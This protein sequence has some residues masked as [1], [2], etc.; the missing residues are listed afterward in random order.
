MKRLLKRLRRWSLQKYFSKPKETGET[1]ST[2]VTAPDVWDEPFAAT[3][4]DRDPRSFNLPLNGSPFPELPTQHHVP[5]SGE[6]AEIGRTCGP[7]AT[8][9]VVET[10]ATTTSPP[11]YILY[12]DESPSQCLQLQRSTSN[13]SS[14]A[15]K[16]LPSKDEQGRV[17]ESLPTMMIEALPYRGHGM[18]SPSI[19]PTTQRPG[20]SDSCDDLITVHE[21]FPPHLSRSFLAR[22]H[23][24]T[25]LRLTVSVETGNFTESTDEDR[26]KSI[27]YRSDGLGWHETLR[28]SPPDPFLRNENLR[29]RI[30]AIRC[31]KLMSRRNEDITAE[32]RWSRAP[33]AFGEMHDPLAVRR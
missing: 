11:S 33:E 25:T 19:D 18:Q 4:F 8:S 30:C 28:Q 22:R 31:C 15:D 17:E 2:L 20:V 32:F 7:D 9:E 27:T 3:Y 26:I 6:L 16:S 14:Y 5:N 1:S 12:D 24:T 21:S 13:Q 23:S 29:W 10:K